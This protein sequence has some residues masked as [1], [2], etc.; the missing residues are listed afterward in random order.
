MNDLH[1]WRDF[2]VCKVFIYAD[3]VI[4]LYNVDGASNEGCE[5][6][7][8]DCLGCVSLGI[9]ENRLTLSPSKTEAISFSSVVYLSL[10]MGFYLRD[11]M[12][13]NGPSFDKH[14]DIISDR[15]WSALRM[16][17]ATNV[18]LTLH[19][20]LKLS[21]AFLTSRIVYC[22]EVVSA[23]PLASPEPNFSI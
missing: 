4:L 19:I 22:F 15:V 16:I 6:Y 1:L 17:Y 2:E 9:F 7:A 18:Y 11:V 14:V 23:S 5:R 12:I 3:A 10:D 20:R 21:H 8:F 13:D